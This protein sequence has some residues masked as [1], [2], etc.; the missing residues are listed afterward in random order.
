MYAEVAPRKVRGRKWMLDVTGHHARPDVFELT[1]HPEAHP[2]IR[3]AE[4][5]ALGEKG[6][7]EA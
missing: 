7:E 4:E 3:V 6:M 5:S 2:M 1:V